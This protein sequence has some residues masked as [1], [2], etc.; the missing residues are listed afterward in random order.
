ML[1]KKEQ[2][3]ERYLKLHKTFPQL[4]PNWDSLLV[5]FKIFGRLG[6]LL[7]IPNL[8]LDYFC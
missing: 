2:T 8:S 4:Y 1:G 5:A 3:I 7:L 6:L